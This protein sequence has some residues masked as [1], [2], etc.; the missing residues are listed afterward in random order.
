MNTPFA[1]AIVSSLLIGSAIPALAQAPEDAARQTVIEEAQAQKSETLQPYVPTKSERVVSKF[2]STYVYPTQTWHPFFDNAYA[3]GG[4][5][6]GAGYMTHVSAY[7]TIDVRASYSIRDYKRVEAEFVSPRLFNRRGE[8]S[9]LGGWRDATQVAFYGIGTDTSNDNR[10]NF[11]FERPY[12][13]GVLTVRPTRRLLML[14]GGLEWTR[15]DLK[16]GAG[17]FPSVDDV[18]T[19]AQLPGLDATATYVH[20]QGTVGFDWRTS[21]GYARRGGFYGVTAHDYHDRGDALGFR[22]VDYEVIQHIPILREAWV[23]SLHG[24]AKTTWGK[25]GQEEPFFMLPA[26][27]GGSSLRGFSSWRFRDR[28]SLLLQ[29]EWR[30]MANRFFDTAV[31]YDTGKVAPRSSDLDFHGLKHD[32]GFGARF[33]TPFSTAL[34]VDV[35]RSDEGTRLVFGMSPAF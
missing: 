7:S 21:S 20:S 4:F 14:R 10:A 25:E 33:H 26:L 17:S 12:A 24:L 2:E 18:F 16:S 31:F 15:W 34:R 23:I 8:L 13:S 1:L 29:A 27:G 19:P 11:G 28:H 9:V 35:A 32:Y 30:I 5:A 3:G 22:Q 6:L